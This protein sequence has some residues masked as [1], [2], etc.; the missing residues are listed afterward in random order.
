[1][2]EAALDAILGRGPVI[3]VVELERADDAVPVCSALQDGGVRTIEILLRTPAALAALEAA[4][5]LASGDLVIGAGTVL[6]PAQMGEAVRAG[7][8]FAV[9]PGFLPALAEAARG[10]GVP[11]LPGVATCSE[12]MAARAAGLTRLK[13]FPA[14]AAG[15]VPALGAIAG[16]FPDVR[17]CPTGGIR[18]GTAAAYLA[19]PN[20]ACVGGS[21]LAPR[22]LVANRDWKAIQNL[23]RAASALSQR[24]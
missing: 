2:S 1:V 20:V 10:H 14:E 11:F 23:A 12:I 9:S 8:R 22:D 3:A 5:P 7:A 16:P 4:A 21:W 18:A 13:F 19:L 6:D 24:G 15:G 17:F